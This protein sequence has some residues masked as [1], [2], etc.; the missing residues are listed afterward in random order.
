MVGSRSTS[1]RRTVDDLL[2]NRYTATNRVEFIKGQ[3]A[4]RVHDVSSIQ[5]V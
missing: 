4:F 2:L 1:G 3:F 5:L